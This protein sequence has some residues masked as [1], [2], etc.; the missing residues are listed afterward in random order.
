MSRTAPSPHRIDPENRHDRA[1]ET[2]SAA[3]TRQEG[4]A[5]ELMSG[6]GIGV[7]SVSHNQL[8]R[9]GWKVELIPVGFFSCPHWFRPDPGLSS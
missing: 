4:A 9:L 8:V 6:G 5:A 7:N 2:R 1:V 3:K